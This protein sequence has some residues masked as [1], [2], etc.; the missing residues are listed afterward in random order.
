MKKII[1]G[2]VIMLSITMMSFTTKQNNYVKVVE[3]DYS[4]DTDSEF[5][6][7]TFTYTLIATNSITGEQQFH[8]FTHS[9]YASSESECQTAA[10][11]HMEV[12]R[13][14]LA[15]ELNS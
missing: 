6:V 14:V 15:T 5:G 12:H 4:L 7:C 3:L 1:L 10:R 9:T 2:L 8:T 13:M 11:I